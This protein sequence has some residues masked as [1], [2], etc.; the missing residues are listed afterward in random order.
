MDN[1]RSRRNREEKATHER[2]SLLLLLPVVQSVGTVIILTMES[3]STELR[4]RG[5]G[6]QLK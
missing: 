6:R 4:K 3:G 5:E 2:R 1:V